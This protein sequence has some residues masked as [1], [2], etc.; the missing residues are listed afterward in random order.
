MISLYNKTNAEFPLIYYIILDII[1]KISINQFKYEQFQCLIHSKCIFYGC[2]IIFKHSVRILSTYVDEG[3]QKQTQYSAFVSFECVM[4]KTQRRPN[5]ELARVYRIL[6]LM[7]LNLIENLSNVP[8]VFMRCIR[9]VCFRQCNVHR[10]HALV[11]IRF[12]G[13]FNLD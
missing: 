13:L 6:S 9:R 8:H 7:S 11:E 2:Q 5:F 1:K 3:P 4:V 10:K 12:Y